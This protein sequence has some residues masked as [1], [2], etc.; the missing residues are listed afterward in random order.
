MYMN[1]Y[2]YEDMYTVK[3]NKFAIASLACGIISIITFSSVYI[4]LVLGSLAVIFAFLSRNGNETLHTY[5]KIGIVLGII[6]VVGVIALS[7]FVYINLPRLLQIPEYRD[8]L[9]NMIN[10]L[11]GEDVDIDEILGMTKYNYLFRL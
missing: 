8:M 11:M 4:P 10:N 2:D 9:Q 3:K 7:I 5:S 1:Q 6:C